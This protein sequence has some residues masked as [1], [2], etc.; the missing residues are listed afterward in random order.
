MKTTLV[1]VTISLCMKTAST[2]Q[3][4]TSTKAV[5]KQE[6]CIYQGGII[7]MVL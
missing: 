5:T 6:L 7:V 2:Q 4:K 3:N 1:V